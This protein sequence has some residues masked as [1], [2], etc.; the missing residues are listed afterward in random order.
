MNPGI[1]GVYIVQFDHFPPPLFL[2]QFF[3]PTTNFAA[4]GAAA[5]PC[6]PLPQTYPSKIALKNGGKG[7]KNASFWG[8]KFQKF[9]RG[10]LPTPLPSD[11]T[12]MSVE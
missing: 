3:S 1:S 2:D 6:T 11:G 4:G 10:G 5:P 12:N 8:H 9:S 7:L